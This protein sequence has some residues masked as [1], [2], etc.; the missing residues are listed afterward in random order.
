MHFRSPSLAAAVLVALLSAG[1]GSTAEDFRPDSVVDLSGSVPATFEVTPSVE[2]LTVRG[3]APRSP[4]TLVRAGTLERLVTLYTDDQGQL[5]IQAL[6]AAY[7]VH[8]SQTQGLPPT[9]GSRPVP[10]GLYRV[11]AEGVPGEPFEG[12]V[13]ATDPFYVLAVGDVP[14][15]SAYEGQNLKSV[16]NGILGGVVGDFTD[17]DGFGYLRVRDGTLLSVNVRLPD[18]RIYGPG[19]YPTVVQ[20]SGYAPSRPGEPGGADAGGRIALSFGF[21]YVGVNMRG[22]GCSGGVFDTFSPAQAADGYDV[23]EIVARQPWVKNGR[24]GM[25]GISYSGITQLYV[26]AT[27][28]PSLAAITPLS[29]IEDPWEQQ[30]PGGIYNAGFTREWLASRDEE[31]SG[32]AGWAKKR[33]LEGDTTCADNLQIRSQNVSF[34]KFAR[35]LVTRPIGADERNLSLL[36]R[37]IDVPVFLASSW[38]DE[39]TG[40]RFGLMLDDFDSV[41]PGQARFTMYNGHHQDPFSPLLMNRWFEFLSLYVDRT[42]PVLNPVVRA[43]IA[44]VVADIFGVPGV[45][46]EGDRFAQFGDD[47]AGAA[48]AYEA[49]NPVRV[50][51]ESGASPI[52]PEVPMAQRERFEM[53]FPSWPPPAAE[54]RSFWFGA[55]GVLLDEAPG[56]SGLETYAFDPDVG[57]THYHVRGDHTNVRVVNDWRPTKNGYGLAWESE[58]LAEDLVVAGQGHVDLWIR[59]TGTDV[60]IEVVLSEVYP[61]SEGRVEEVRVQHGLARAGFRRV[62]PSRSTDLQPNNFYTAASYEPLSPGEFVNVKVPVYSVSH[63][64]RAGSRLRIEVNTPG[65][66]AAL[67]DFEV[68]SY[69]ATSHDVGFGGDVA[70]RLV[71]PVLPASDPAYA[72]PARFAPQSERPRC[73]HLRGQPCREY[74]PASNL[75]R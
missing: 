23:I 2:Y 49:E 55:G 65:G 27:N 9:E 66:D 38:H 50:L 39:Q 16:P 25:I 42:V 54:A 10:P 74:Q 28:P 51:F 68:D 20:Y 75:A 57:R 29:V 67:W 11:V 36:V 7:L 40:P 43:G 58:P 69:G 5:V 37:K 70:S 19:P 26:A 15:P 71:L 56:A 31:S 32:G 59:S 46:L 73:D 62:D 24:V 63:P 41:P 48:A 13:Q 35:S 14:D 6:P 61:E 47:A 12:K 18:P 45:V 52:Y 72:I 3:A 4:L 64:F 8:D 53:G 34:E 17:D 22:T 44:P 60:P 21:A 33:I 30:W 1:C